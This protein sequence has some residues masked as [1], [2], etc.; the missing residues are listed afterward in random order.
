[1][2]PSITKSAMLNGL[3]MGVIFSINFLFSVS[4]VTSLI[5]FTNIIA[6]LIVVWVYRTTV[7]FRDNECEGFISYW[8]AFSYILYTFFFAALISSV[9]KFIYFQFINPAYLDS[10]YQD[11]MKMLTAWKYPIDDAMEEQTK[12]MLKP[13]SYT[14]VYIWINAL[15]GIIVG[16]ILAGFIKKN[17]T[18]FE[19]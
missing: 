5:M 9:V 6:I 1:M 7:K 4:K 19:E 17:K 11:T 3:I 14:L 15:L 16:L 10:I 12:K 13:A 2:Q 18:I 8:R